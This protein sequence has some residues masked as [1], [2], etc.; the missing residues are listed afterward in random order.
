MRESEPTS[1]ELQR[2]IAAR[3]E[4]LGMTQNELAKKLHISRQRVTQL[5]GSGGRGGWPSPEIFN[6]LARA[7]DVPVS[8]LLRRAGIAFGEELRHEQLDWVISQLDDDGRD[9]LSEIGRA[10]L[11]RH[12]RLA[13][14]GE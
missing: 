1:Q 7:L 9:Q 6:G 5:E 8:V 14:K 3:R 4:E 2:Y 10:I 13:E 11:P 12:L